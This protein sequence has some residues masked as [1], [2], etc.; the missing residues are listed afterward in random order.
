MTLLTHFI[1]LW[2]A[3]A[4]LLLLIWIVLIEVGNVRR[5]RDLRRIEREWRDFDRARDITGGRR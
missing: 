3:G 2:F 4:T 5:N 1:V